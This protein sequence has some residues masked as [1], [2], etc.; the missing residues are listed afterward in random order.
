MDGFGVAA[1]A[2]RGPPDAADAAEWAEAYGLELPVLA[3]TEGVLQTRWSIDGWPTVLVVAADGTVLWRNAG[4]TTD[5]MIAA[6]V[7]D[8]WAQQ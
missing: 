4:V 3:D 6:Q 7:R 5:A 8:A 1:R 2:Q